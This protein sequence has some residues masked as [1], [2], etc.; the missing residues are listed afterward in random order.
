MKTM[1]QF[2]QDAASGK[3]SL[4]L[5]ERYG[6]TDI[7][8]SINGIRRVTE[9]NKLGIVFVDKNGEESLMVLENNRLREY[10]GS[11][12]TIYSPGYRDLLG[13]EKSMLAEWE[14]IQEEYEKENPH[15]NLFW[16]RMAFFERSPYPWLNGFEEMNGK[17]LVYDEHGVSKIKDD[18]IKGDVALKYRVYMEA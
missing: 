7:P 11:T 3:M 16:K 4:E 14:K 18:T 15:T 6:S 5:I 1:E 13:P 10:D 8:E 12:L 9:A 2:K 17:M